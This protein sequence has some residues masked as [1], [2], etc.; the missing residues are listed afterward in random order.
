MIETLKTHDSAA[1]VLKMAWAKFAAIW[2]WY[3]VPHNT[4]LY[5]Y[6]LHAPVLKWMPIGF[7][8]VAA[9]ALVGMVVSWRRR[10][11]CWPLYLL[12]AVNLVVLGVFGTNGRYRI[13][14]LAAL[15]IVAI[16][17]AAMVGSLQAFGWAKQ[18]PDL[19]REHPPAESRV[20]QTVVAKTRELAGVAPPSE[21]TESPAPEASAPPQRTAAEPEPLRDIEWFDPDE[22]LELRQPW[23]R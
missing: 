12:V 21:A 18:V 9:P 22:E 16:T 1:S 8:V 6:G 23:D 10:A 17:G 5:Y 3:Q 14:L 19:L 11:V 4:N 13:V 20:W 2:H 7:L 15:G